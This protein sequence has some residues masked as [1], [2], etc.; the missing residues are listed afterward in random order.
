MQSLCAHEFIVMLSRPA[1]H[2]GKARTHMHHHRHRRH[3]SPLAPFGVRYRDAVQLQTLNGFAPHGKASTR[4]V[5]RKEQR[6]GA[7]L[8]MRTRWRVSVS[9][10]PPPLRFTNRRHL[11]VLRTHARHCMHTYAHKSVSKRGRTNA[12]H[13]PRRESRAHTRQRQEIQ[14]EEE[15]GVGFEHA[16]IHTCPHPHNSGLRITPTR[17]TSGQRTK[18]SKGSPADA[19]V[20]VFC[21]PGHSGEGRTTEERESVCLCLRVCA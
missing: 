9:L 11:Q 13:V 10:P 16:H 6:R 19:A 8:H 4:D 18:R 12:T 17:A 3:R 2:L 14:E 7:P 21:A 20:S 15:G 5:E 1:T